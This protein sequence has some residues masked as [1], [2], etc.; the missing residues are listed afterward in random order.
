MIPLDHYEENIRTLLDFIQKN[1]TANVI[2]ATTTPVRDEYV[3]RRHQEY[4]DFVRYNRDV[5]RYNNAS[6]KVAEDMSVYINDLYGT[7][8]EAGMA[9]IQ[10]E[11]GVHYSDKGSK[12]LAQEVIASI[13]AVL[14]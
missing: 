10:N 4:Q 5:I 7:V 3:Y 13:Q 11:D 2:W 9:D 14:K 1:T 6:R 12:L 8:M